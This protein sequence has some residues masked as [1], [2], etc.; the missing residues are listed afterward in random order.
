MANKKSSLKDVRRIAKR[1][2]RN[3]ETRSALKTYIKK[4]RQANDAGDTATIPSKLVEAASQLDRAVQR[5]IIHKNQA[6]RRKS[7]IAKAAAAVLKAGPSSAPI[8]APKAEKAAAA[9]KAAPAK[10]ATANKPTAEK[11]PEAD[12]KPVVKKAAPKKAKE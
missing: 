9:K 12:K 8:A 2:V 7:R 3:R 6:A 11:K 10:K 1:T 5:G 4:V